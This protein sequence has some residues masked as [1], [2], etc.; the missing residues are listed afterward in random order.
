MQKTELNGFLKSLN[1]LETKLDR[2]NKVRER[3]DKLQAEL[4]FAKKMELPDYKMIGIYQPLVNQLI[5]ENSLLFEMQNSEMLEDI[6]Q[7]LE[8]NQAYI[9][10]TKEQ[11]DE[12]ESLGAKSVKQQPQQ[13]NKKVQEL[14]AEL[15]ERQQRLQQRNKRVKELNDKVDWLQKKRQNSKELSKKEQ[16]LLKLY[17]TPKQYFL[18][19]KKWYV[20]VLG[21][22]F[23][24]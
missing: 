19:S 10:T 1:E 20:R 7:L 8:L 21:I 15:K 16:K 9:K 24:K 17:N 6:Q 18:D 12:I 14:N 13:N 3:V 22:F 5:Q 4:L 11:F 23:R 2:K